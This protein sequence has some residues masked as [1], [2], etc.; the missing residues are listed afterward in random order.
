MNVDI[1]HRRELKGSYFI[2]EGA[3]GRSGYREKHIVIVTGR[4]EIDDMAN[5]F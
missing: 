1:N 3:M 5:L 4:N 2:V